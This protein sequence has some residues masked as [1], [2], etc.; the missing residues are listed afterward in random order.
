MK[1]KNILI[2]ILILIIILFVPLIPFKALNYMYGGNMGAEGSVAC[3]H[4]VYSLSGLVIEYS[5][6]AGTT[7]SLMGGTEKLQYDFFACYRKGELYQDLYRG[8]ERWY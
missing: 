1:K 7:F 6:M 5:K 3:Y 2:T 4:R 8:D